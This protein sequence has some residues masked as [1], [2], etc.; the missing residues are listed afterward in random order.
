MDLL[1]K[2]YLEIN[3]VPV[4]ENSFGF[5]DK[6]CNLLICLIDF[7][8]GENQPGKQQINKSVRNYSVA[9]YLTPS[10]SHLLIRV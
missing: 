5:I 1:Q 10:D 8:S 2:S 3:C 4:T 7:V 9:N 6:V